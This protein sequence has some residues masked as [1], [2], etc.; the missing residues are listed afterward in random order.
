MSPDLPLLFESRPA[1]VPV[2][3]AQGPELVAGRPPGICMR[4]G[5]ASHRRADALADDLAKD[6]GLN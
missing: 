2:R 3:P 1:V 6:C 4:E 5:V